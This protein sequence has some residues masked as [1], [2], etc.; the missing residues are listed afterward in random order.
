MVVFVA[1][2]VRLTCS[3]VMPEGIA[4]TLNVHVALTASTRLAVQALE[5]RVK[6]AVSV[7][8]MVMGLETANVTDTLPLFVTVPVTVALVCP[9]TVLDKIS[10]RGVIS[11]LGVDTA[12]PVAVNVAEAL[13]VVEEKV[14][15][16]DSAPMIDGVTLRDF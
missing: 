12:V 14:A 10:G 9:C 13:A 6:S 3:R 4:L 16:A 11:R 1:V 7:P 15:V 5:L 8:V 2:A